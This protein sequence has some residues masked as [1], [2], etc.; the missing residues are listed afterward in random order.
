[1]MPR[2]SPAQGDH[3]ARLPGKHDVALSQGFE[4]QPVS[5]PDKI[6]QARAMVAA[7]QMPTT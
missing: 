1:M 2:D 6:R 3:P 7:R 5:G 4:E